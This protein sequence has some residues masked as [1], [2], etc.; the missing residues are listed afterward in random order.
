MKKQVLVFV[1]AGVLLG[2]TGAFAQDEIIDHMMK[3]CETEINT[4]CSQ[5]MPGEGRL[6]ACFFAHED[7][8]SGRCQ[9]ALY[10]GAAVLEDFTMAVTHVATECHDDLLKFCGEVEVG[11]GRVGTCLVEHK[12]EVAESCR[13]A[14]DDVGLEIVEEE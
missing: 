2:A 7:K 4:Y 9:Y 12:A 1:M 13:Q 11:E 6:L 3:A 5:V 10:E 14:M 8:I